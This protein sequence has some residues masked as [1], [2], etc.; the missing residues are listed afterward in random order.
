M[1][2][3]LFIYALCALCPAIFTRVAGAGWEFIQN[4]TSGVLALETI[5]VSPTLAVFFDFATT[6]DPLQINNH[7]AWG[8]LWNLETNEVTALNVVSDTFCASGGLL[9]NGTMVSV[10]GNLNFVGG[11]S[12]GID[13]RM[14]LRIFE[15]CASPSGEGCTLYDDPDTVHLTENRWYPTTLRI[16][17]GSLMVVGGIHEV[18]PFYNTDPVNNFEFFPAKDGTVPRPSAFLERSLPSNL[19]PRAFALPDGKVFMVANNQSIIYDIEANTETILPDIPNGVRVTNPFDGTATLLP[20]SPPLYIPE[21]LVCGGTNASDQIP[22]ANLSSQDPASDQCS[23]ITLTAAGI[24]KGWE[25]EHMLEGRMMPE[26]ILLPSGEVLIING[27][28]TGYA[29]IAGVHDAVGNSN[30]DNPVLTPSL[31]NPSAPLGQRISNKG[32]P[33]TEIPRMY[34]S[35]ASL[36][37]SGNILIAGSNPNL[38]VNTTVKF[39]TEYRVEYLNPPYMSLDRP[40]LTG[41]PSK[42][43]FNSNFT[44]QVT[45][46]DHVGSHP[47]IKVALMDLGFS[48]HSFHSSSRLVWLEATLSHDHKLL[49]ISSPPNNRVYPPGPA[50]IFL[51]VG[52]TTSAGIHVMVGSGASPPV[53]DQGRRI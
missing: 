53:P 26:M 15:P 31:Y 39:S 48:S 9:S 52:D 29:A 32:L 5:I 44:A 42:I 50:Y 33:A 46:P 10:G 40:T 27:A 16:F 11:T 41:V 3:S 6:G 21:I 12:P 25:V 7:S 19:F 23:R 2:S 43:A 14:G 18:T 35:T 51:T 13:G 47:V 38:D 8:G 49:E 20:L 45:I 37:P 34:H 1:K 28:Q 4:G 22:V 24:K 36:T 17:D 30:A